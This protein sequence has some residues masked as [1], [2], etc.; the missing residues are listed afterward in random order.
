[1]GLREEP[2]LF[3]QE[4][5][6]KIGVQ[7]DIIESTPIRVLI[8]TKTAEKVLRDEKRIWNMVCGLWFVI[9]QFFIKKILHIVLLSVDV[10]KKFVFVHVLST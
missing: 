5:C 9:W 2:D 6:K 1:M 4:D 7:N 10:F 8:V 3:P